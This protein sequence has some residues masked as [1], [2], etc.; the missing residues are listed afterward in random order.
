[1]FLFFSQQNRQIKS[2]NNDN[3]NNQQ[4]QQEEQEQTLTKTQNIP[5]SIKINT[6]LK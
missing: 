6:I 1:M 4:Q 5:P 2:I 3:L